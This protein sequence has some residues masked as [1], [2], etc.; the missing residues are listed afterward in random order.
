MP[1]VKH[2]KVLLDARGLSTTGC[3]MELEKRLKDADA[4]PS[5][6]VLIKNS[7]TP[8][9]I[10]ARKMCARKHDKKVQWSNGVSPHEANFEYDEV[11]SQATP[12]ATKPES[13]PIEARRKPH[14]EAPSP[15]PP[16]SENIVADQDA[17]PTPPGKS[18]EVLTPCQPPP[19]TE[20]AD[21]GIMVSSSKTKKRAPPCWQPNRPSMFTKPKSKPTASAASEF[22][23]FSPTKSGTSESQS[24]ARGAHATA[25]TPIGTAEPR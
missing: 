19:R 17:W 18:R 25:D 8:K 14:R 13:A 7:L 1:T 4:G 11:Q 2:L 21:I 24:D 12:P 15:P 5:T 9:P 20:A 23:C 10:G 16:K 22:G 6:S 3:K